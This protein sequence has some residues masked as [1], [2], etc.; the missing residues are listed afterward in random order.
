MRLSA[1]QQKLLRD[2]RDVIANEVCDACGK[3]LGSV[4]FTR[5]GE[6]GEWCSR[7]CREGKAE[8]EAFEAK[9][10][11]RGRPL[12]ELS[13]TAKTKRLRTQQRQASRR[14]RER[15]KKL[16]AAD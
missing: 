14:Y 3:V 4:R 1:E 16:S 6:P 11:A 5:R 7:E 10:A 2:E 13:E 9:R 15:H 12:L 8:A